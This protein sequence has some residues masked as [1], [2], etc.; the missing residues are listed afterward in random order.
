MKELCLNALR[1]I[2]MLLMI[3][4]VLLLEDRDDLPPHIN[5]DDDEPSDPA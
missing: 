4:C 2:A 3:A 5:G 1:S